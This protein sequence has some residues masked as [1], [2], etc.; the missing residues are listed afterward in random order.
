MTILAP[1]TDAVRTEWQARVAAEYAVCA[2][3]QE[4]ARRLT[5]FGSPPELI[6]QA[7]TMALDELAHARLAAEV[8][9]ASGAQGAVIF[10]PDEFAV[11]TA[12]HPA[13]NIA[14]A[15][16][17]SLCLGETLALRLIHHLRDNARVDAA[18]RALD[19]VV[20]DEPRH[21][22][23]GWETLDWLLDGP[24]AEVVRDAV[25][26][27]LPRWV[28][29]LRGSFAGPVPEPHLGSLGDG[30]LLWGLAPVGDYRAVFEETVERDWKPRL[31]RRGFHLG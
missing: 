26:H 24:D 7:L 9:A 30:D 5:L 12:E 1:A 23:L 19:R 16:V 14:V 21:A 15:A 8:C 27:A 13:V 31:A 2:V 22:A 4:L 10:D 29:T 28:D 17:P 25:E 3:A 20:A 11:E 18:R 6:E